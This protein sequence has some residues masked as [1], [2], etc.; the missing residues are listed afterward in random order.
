MSNNKNGNSKLDPKGMR[1]TIKKN[2]FFG[3]YF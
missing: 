1:K 3:G 2:Y